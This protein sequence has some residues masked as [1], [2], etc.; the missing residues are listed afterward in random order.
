MATEKK[1]K[2]IHTEASPH[3]GGQ[4]IRIFEEMK[5]FREQGHEMILVAP[6]NGTLYQRCK[7]E[8]FEVI[9]IYF[10][11]PRTLLNILRMIWVIWRKKPNIVATHSSTDSW[12]GLIAASLNN[13]R[14]R[15]RYRHVSTPI[16][17]N[18]LN[19]FQYSI[20][21]N[22]TITTGN[23][24]RA[25]IIDKFNTNKDKVYSIPTAISPPSHLK[26]RTAARKLLSNEI[27]DVANKFIIGQV[28]VLRSWKGHKVLIDAFNILN[29]IHKNTS[30]VIVGDGPVKSDIEG[31]IKA[32]KNNGK[33]HLLGHKEDPFIFL[34]AFDL[35][36]L[37]S[38]KNEGIPQSILQAMYCQTPVIG[39]SIG[40]IP[41]IINHGVT[42]F[43]VEPNNAYQ[44]ANLIISV[45]KDYEKSEEMARTAHHFVNLEFSKHKLWSK[46]MN[47]FS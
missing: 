18:R 7:D 17:K 35:K 26:D 27:P 31:Y 6:D 16:K 9:S 21:S 22:L 43:I 40:G 46:L 2:I 34:R 11:K 38:T 10:T 19:E 15:V 1:L 13:V 45:M 41:E 23:C 29:S 42:G 5:W 12:A 4:E 14:K 24:I 33:I 3:W 8:D 28:S 44:L 37:A 36:V 20:L 47:V 39:T 32:T 25:D 30:L